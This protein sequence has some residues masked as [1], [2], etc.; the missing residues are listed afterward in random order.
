MSA[1]EKEEGLKDT[2]KGENSQRINLYFVFF[3]RPAKFELSVALLQRQRD[4]SERRAEKNKQP[5]S[6]ACHRDAGTRRRNLCK[7]TDHI[8][9]RLKY[10][11]RFPQAGAR[12]RELE[13]LLTHGCGLLQRW[14]RNR[15]VIKIGSK[16]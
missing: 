11:S 1:R 13:G 9:P 8:V 4:T 3:L 14:G 7:L 6:V 5:R 2:G 16:K 12:H 15:L 10:L